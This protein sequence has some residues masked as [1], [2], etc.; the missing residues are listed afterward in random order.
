MRLPPS[1]SAH[2][3]FTPY[4]AWMLLCQLS[5]D[6]METVRNVPPSHLARWCSWHKAA[7]VMYVDQPVGTGLSFTTNANYADNELEVRL[8]SSP[9]CGP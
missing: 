6:D 7:N 8:A 2:D 1:Y 4:N 5:W 9:P 3:L